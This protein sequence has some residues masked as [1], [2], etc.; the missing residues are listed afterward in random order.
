MYIRPLA[1]YH[2]DHLDRLVYCHQ[3]NLYG[4]SGPCWTGHLCIES[5]VKR[6]LRPRTP[7]QLS[8]TFEPA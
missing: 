3:H 1:R 8:M 7:I 4:Y 5:Q 2:L 6:G